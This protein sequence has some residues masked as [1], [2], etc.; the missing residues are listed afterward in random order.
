MSVIGL[1]HIFV[2]MPLL[3][4]LYFNKEKL[5]NTV[6]MI[7]MAAGVGGI[8]YH[9]YKV[10]DSKTK[11]VNLIHIFIVFPLLIYIGYNC[12]T[13]KMKY[14]E[15]LLMIAFAGLGYHSYWTLK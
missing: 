14:F 3:F 12:E 5:N 8:L 10:V 9:L 13:T 7:L 1:V 11:W 2:F 15:F 6:C 4:Y